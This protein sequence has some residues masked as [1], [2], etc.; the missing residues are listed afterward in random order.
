MGTIKSSEECPFLDS[1]FSNHTIKNGVKNIWPKWLETCIHPKDLS[2]HMF[3]ILLARL[4]LSLINSHRYYLQTHSSLMEVNRES[5][6]FQDNECFYRFGKSMRNNSEMPRVSFTESSFEVS[7]HVK[8]ANNK[9]KLS[10]DFDLLNKNF[11]PS[12]IK[13]KKI[14]NEKESNVPHSLVTPLSSINENYSLCKNK[15]K[16]FQT[17]SHQLG[18]KELGYKN[19]FIPNIIDSSFHE[20]DLIQRRL[21]I[22]LKIWG[23]LQINIDKDVTLCATLKDLCIE[24]ISREI[25][26]KF[27]TK[28]LFLVPLKYLRMSSVINC[29]NDQNNKN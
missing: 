5:P 2:I 3:V 17:L 20:E 8:L 7:P 26:A 10:E 24:F 19:N 25:I 12:K 4:E 6:N 29:L 9:L 18:L 28:D 23:N 11:L 1:E 13:I 16:C 21:N 27:R 22:L 14:E 15:P